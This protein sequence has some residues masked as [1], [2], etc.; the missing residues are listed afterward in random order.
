MLADT[1]KTEIEQDFA[2][3]Y[4]KLL[5]KYYYKQITV[6]KLVE[7]AGYG[8]ATF[9]GYF[10]GLKELRVTLFEYDIEQVRN[11]CISALETSDDAERCKL[12]IEFANDHIKK[13]WPLISENNNIEHADNMKKMLIEIFE[14]DF[15]KRYSGSS[16]D[17]ELITD[18]C[19][20]GVMR[21]TLAHYSGTEGM[22][23]P[24][25]DESFTEFIDYIMFMLD[26]H[27]FNK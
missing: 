26:R 11:F 5:E 4:L 15:A 20:A 23:T 19:V 25:T 7:T 24:R 22:K 18:F 17:P 1:F 27:G 16:F 21:M 2:V 10:S 12:M 13:F 9:Y 3:A 8:R 6:T 14:K